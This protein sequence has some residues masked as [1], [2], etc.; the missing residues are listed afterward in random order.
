MVHQLLVDQGLHPEQIKLQ[1]FRRD[2]PPLTRRLKELFSLVGDEAEVAVVVEELV[3][4]EGSA[5]YPWFSLTM[6][7]I[8]RVADELGVPDGAWRFI[9]PIKALPPR[10]R[11]RAWRIMEA[12]A[13]DL[14][15]MRYDKIGTYTELLEDICMVGRAGF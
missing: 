13:D 5:F 12:W 8:G 10:E 9:G 15:A 6:D 1:L 2:R 4:R 14:A 11:E 7:N 3:R